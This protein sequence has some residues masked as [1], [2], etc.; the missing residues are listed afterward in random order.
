MYE[1]YQRL[2]D[3]NGIKTSDVAKATGISNMTFSD[4][5]SGKYV[6]KMDKMQKI[7]DYFGVDVKYL[8][9]GKEDT[10]TPE[11]SE[12]YLDLISAYDK[13][14]NENKTAIMQIIKSLSA[15]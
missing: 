2:L 15:K 11:L 3:K 6:P 7:A 8:T 10:P 1:I 9:T 5:K 14:S 13:L 4:W 12:E